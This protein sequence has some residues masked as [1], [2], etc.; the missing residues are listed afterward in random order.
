MFIMLLTSMLTVALK[1]QLARASGT[2]YIRAD[3]SVE[4]T[5]NIQTA[6]NTTYVFIADINA[7]IVVERSS[8]VIDGNGYTLQGAGFS[9]L[10]TSG[11]GIYLS[12]RTNVT[13]KNTQIKGFLDGIYLVSSSNNTVSRNNITSNTDGMYIFSSSSNSVSGNNI[14]NN[15]LG[16]ALVAGSSNN[17]ISG[18]NITNNANAIYIQSFSDYNSISGNNITNSQAMGI[19]L[20][21]SSGN[22]LAGNT[23]ANNLENFG[24][25]GSS[26]SDFVNNVDAS[27]TVDGKPVYYW[28]DRQ[29]MT[30]P[31]D[32]GYVALVNCTGITVQNLTLTSNE[33]GILLAYTTNSTITTNDIRNNLVGIWLI[34]S[35]NN[36]ISQNIFMNDGMF[37]SDSYRNVVNG[38]LVNGK[39]LV[40]LE[41]V[42]GYAVNNAGEVILVNSS[43]I[44][45]ENLDLSDATV[46]V[47]LWASSNNVISGDN[48]TDNGLYGI[49]VESSS[50]YN[51]ISGNNITTLNW[52]GIYLVSSSNNTVSRNNLANNGFGIGLFS[53]SGNMIYHNSF[54]NYALQVVSSRSMNA[55][56]DGYPSGGNHWSD[57]TGADLYSGP[58]Q[59]ETGADGI[60]DTPYVI[61]AN[62]RDDYPLV[63]HDVAVRDVEPLKTIVGQGYMLPVNAKVANTGGYFEEFNVTLYASAI[64]TASQ[65]STIASGNS[66][67]L[68]FTWN[69]T[70]FAYGNYTL[71]VYAWPVPGE[72][73][74]ADN[75]LTGS[76]ISVTI[77]GDINGDFTVDIYDALTLSGAYNSMPKSSSWNTNADINNDSIVD[78]YDAIIL[79][80]NYGK[81]A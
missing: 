42:S 59:N 23:I 36:T 31:L 57:Y 53:S 70:G 74:T 75:N 26:L 61:E 27:N 16:I 35:S 20:L 56:D 80:N 18:N 40:Y 64:A 33:Q 76:V 45:I 67:T 55:W 38:N 12:Q 77:P 46:G 5:T 48:L 39:P 1:I 30:V 41:G 79:A 11:N 60:G 72:T 71:N 29:D 49:A 21:D 2:V 37:V 10:L 43:D 17:T 73:D 66:T 15:G 78:I 19:S 28:V 54:S 8:I 9:P 47:E 52:Y 22:S 13:I 58:Y 32:A 69:T 81:T 63:T 7:H 62:N 4:G 50:D 34:S 68:T 44:R 3:G 65:N 25:E 6:D 24:I 51:S 14:T